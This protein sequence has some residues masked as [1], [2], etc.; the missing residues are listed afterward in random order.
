MV[1]KEKKRV[2]EK[3]NE[4]SDGNVSEVKTKKVKSKNLKRDED[5]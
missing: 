3:I 1:D 5:I 4:K 2:S